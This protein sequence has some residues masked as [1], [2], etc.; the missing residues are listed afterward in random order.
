MIKT[1]YYTMFPAM[2]ISLRQASTITQGKCVYYMK[3]NGKSEI[4]AS[5]D[6]IM[7]T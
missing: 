2:N 4:P 7:D 3:Y 6:E 1:G 5:L